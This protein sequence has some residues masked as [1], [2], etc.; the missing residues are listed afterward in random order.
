[1]QTQINIKKFEESGK[2]AGGWGKLTLPDLAAHSC[3]H[4]FALFCGCIMPWEVSA[5]AAW[6]RGWTKEENKHP[7]SMLGHMSLRGFVRVQARRRECLQIPWHSLRT[8]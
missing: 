1:M 3:Q 5:A 6:T 8:G 2:C 4:E 7:Q